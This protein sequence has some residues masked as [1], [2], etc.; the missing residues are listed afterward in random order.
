MNFGIVAI[1]RHRCLSGLACVF[2][3][4]SQSAGCAFRFPCLADAATVKDE[5]MVC[6][7]P[8]L[9]RYQF[10]ESFLCPFRVLF[11]AQSDSVGYAVDM[12]IHSQARFSE[13]VE[14]NN[15]G[16]F[17]SHTRQLQKGVEVIRDFPF[18]LIQDNPC[19]SHQMSRLIPEQPH[20]F[21][22]FFDMADLSISESLDVKIFFKEE[23]C[24]TV[25]LFIC[26]LG[27]KD[28]GY[29]CLVGVREV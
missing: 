1:K 3:N 7:S 28:G 24:D 8:F 18:M 19:R 4:L 13:G 14:Q 17:S 2:T 15:I 23:R 21:D 5:E 9:F 10:L 16:G 25:D 20:R 11:T 26:C 29:Q 6:L 12:G 27:G 22:Y